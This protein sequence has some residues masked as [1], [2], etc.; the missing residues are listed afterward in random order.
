ML[1]LLKKILGQ[2]GKFYDLL[3]ASAQQAVESSRLLIK[4]HGSIGTP[5]F[6]ANLLE[7]AK[8]RRKDKR[9]GLH[10]THELCQTFVT[11]IERE[12]IE[13][14]ASALYKIPKTTEKIGERISIC[15]SQFTTDI[16]GKQLQ[17]LVQATDVVVEMV[18]LLRKISDVEKIQDAYESLQTIEGDADKFMVGILRDLYQ[19]NVDAKEVLILSDIY[20]LL[21]RAIDLCRDAGKVVFQV[22]LKY[23]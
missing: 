7:L 12:D 11:P 10:I 6:D 18:K 21:E 14:L 8:S 3:E 4:L 1:S 13:A 9:I 17:M 15:P 16:V 2:D 19:G 23:S 5:E 20:E 22:A